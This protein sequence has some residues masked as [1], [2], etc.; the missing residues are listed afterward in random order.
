MDLAVPAVT[1]AVTILG[2]KS[3]LAISRLISKQ[4]NHK[5]DKLI[6]MNGTV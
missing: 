6:N 3:I 4:K 2:S 1:T 5:H